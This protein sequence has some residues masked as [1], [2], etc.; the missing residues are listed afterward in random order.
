MSN[1]ANV[2]VGK[3]KAAGGIFSSDTSATL[4]ANATS[5]LAEDYKNLGLV[6]EAG[7]TNSVETSSEKIIEWGG[8]T[9]LTV[10]VSRDETFS[11]TFIETNADVLKEVYGQDNVTVDG[12]S[13]DIAVL[14]N[15]ADLPQRQY[16]FE[17]AMTGN[18]VKRI[19][20]PLAQ[21]D[22]VGDVVYVAGEAIGY[23]VTLATAPDAAG[24]TAY[25]YIA[26]VV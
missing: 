24:N 1:A 13:G 18:R 19:V 3:P 25:E 8:A 2:S 11:F 5:A 22:E 14:H 9:V 23:E 6:S 15:A 10:R 4:P 26:S 12:E 17:I 21:V 7:L 16:V 20:V